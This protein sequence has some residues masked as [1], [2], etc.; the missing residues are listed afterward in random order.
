MLSRREGRE[1]REALLGCLG[2]IGDG[3][4]GRVGWCSL[5]AGRPFWVKRRS[6]ACTTTFKQKEVA[7]RGPRTTA[8]KC[9]EEHGVRRHIRLIS[10]M[11]GSVTFISQ[12]L[13]R[14]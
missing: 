1:G 3:A 9:G 12:K 8:L 10:S 7:W 6:S 13:P 5:N 11:L 14:G 4:D 2:G